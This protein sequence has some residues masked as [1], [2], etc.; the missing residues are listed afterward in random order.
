MFSPLNYGHPPHKAREMAENILDELGI[1][2]LKDKIIHYLS[3]GEKRKVALAGALVMSPELLVLDEPFSGLDMKSQHAYVRLI[4]DYSRQ[5]GIS[6][7]LSTH[8]IELTVGFA[9]TI[10]LISSQ[11]KLF[12]KGTPKELFCQPKELEKFNL[13]PPAILDLFVRL[14][15]KGIDTEI[16][17]TVDEAVE[18][19]LAKL[20]M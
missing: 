3:G 9:D 4:D 12:L 7:I 17:S 16:P 10:Y 11:N 13:E 15:E 5:K 6:V 1:S 8:D 2:H 20:N 18:L 14:K 19:L